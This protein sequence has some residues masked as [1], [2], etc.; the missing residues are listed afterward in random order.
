MRRESKNNTFEG[1]HPNQRSGVR[2]CKTGEHKGGDDVLG[3][4]TGA[5]ATVPGTLSCDA[6]KLI[7]QQ[8]NW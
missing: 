8:L 6:E 1:V 4:N 5:Y 3:A 7:K 2:I